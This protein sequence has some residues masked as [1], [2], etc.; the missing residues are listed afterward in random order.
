MHPRYIR[1]QLWQLNDRLVKANSI[2][3]AQWRRNQR[4]IALGEMDDWEF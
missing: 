4:R 3:F 2:T 1:Y